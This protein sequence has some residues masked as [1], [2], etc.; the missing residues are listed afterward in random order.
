MQKFFDCGI[1]LGTTNS[2]LAIPDHDHGFEIIDNQADRMSVTPSAVLINGKGRMLIGQRAYNSQKVEDLA[3][4]FK[5]QMGLSKMIRFASAGVEKMPEELS[6]EILRQ[7]RNDAETRLNR[8]IE[9]VVITVPAAFKTLQSEATNKAGKLAG[10]QNIILLQEPIA[11]A[12]AYGAKPDS[13]DKHWMVFDYGGGTLDVAIISTLNNRLTVENSEGDNY[14]GG[15]DIDRMMFREIVLKKLKAEGYHVDA[16]FDESTGSGKSNAR[17][18]QLECERCKIDLSNKESVILEIFDIDDDEGEPIEFECEITRGELEALI[19]DTVDRSITIA[20]KALAG[21]GLQAEQLDKILL[22]GGSTFI[23]LVRQRLSEKFGVA[24]DSSMNP[25]T[26]VAAGAAIYASTSV[27]DVEEEIEISAATEEKHAVISLTFD[28]ISSDETVNVIGKVVNISDV[29][30]SRIKFDCAV[31]KDFAGICWTSGWME[32]LDQNNGIFDADVLLQKGILNYFRVSACDPSGREIVI[33]NPYFEIKH[34]ETV[35]KMSAPP[36]TM[37]IGVQIRDPKTGYDVL[38]HVI[39]K[40]S[41]LPAQDDRTFK[42]SRDIDPMHDD[43]ITIKIWEG[44]NKQNPEANFPAGV[45]TVRSSAMDRMIPKGT[46]VEL[47]IIADENRNIRVSGYI[48]DFDFIIPE[49]T[50]R[51]EAKV[52]LEERMNTVETKIKQSEV[53]IERLKGL[54]V[55][56][57]SLEAE[58]ESVKADFDDAYSKVDSDEASVNAYLDRFYDLE[59]RIIREERKYQQQKDNSK[60]D[61]IVTEARGRVESFGDED[62]KAAFEQLEESYELA[63][64]AEEKSFIANKM[65]NLGFEAMTNN[66]GWLNAFFSL[67]LSKPETKYDNAQK[68]E[69]WKSQAYLAIDSRNTAQLRKA[70]FELLDLMTSSANQAVAAFGADLTM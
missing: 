33:E 2:C 7:L 53:S 22:V 59:S 13:R 21:A 26:V 46:E 28:P 64:T 5:R 44:E 4:Q 47:T 49:E 30:I 58:L 45:I 16:L 63:E 41:P 37:S 32:L 6:A 60:N 61:D 70:V 27:I 39:K 43:C 62:T 69:Y 20:E 10:F 3:I 68:A 1:D 24:L 55:N 19:T 65:N 40:N 11:A 38:H 50:L 17:R 14:F 35:L 12:V 23:P 36:A 34:N 29:D 67:I 25:M 51:A 54:N 31:N 56:V 48:P 15:S 9:N 8:K 18:V 42:L 57:S 66:Y 52:D